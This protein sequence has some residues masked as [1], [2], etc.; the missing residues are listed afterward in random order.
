MHCIT[1]RLQNVLELFIQGG[2][3]RARHNFI[4]SLLE[5][6]VS[7]ISQSGRIIGRNFRL[8]LVYPAA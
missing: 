2:L 7:V 8:L 1:P 6:S 3:G 4:F 5:A